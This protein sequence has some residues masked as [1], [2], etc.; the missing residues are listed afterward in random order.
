MVIAD[1]AMELERQHDGGRTEVQRPHAPCSG[2]HPYCLI[3]SVCGRLVCVN[4]R[5][6]P[7]RKLG[8]SDDL[9]QS[10]LCSTSGI[11]KL[12]GTFRSK[13]DLD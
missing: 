3:G 10:R 5:T 11:Q 9:D 2:G 13:S 12:D 1:D 6:R 8:D 4:R 7:D